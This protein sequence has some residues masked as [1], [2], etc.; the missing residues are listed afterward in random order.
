MD[1]KNGATFG[2][3]DHFGLLPYNLDGLQGRRVPD[4]KI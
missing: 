4:F 3:E 2:I 1:S